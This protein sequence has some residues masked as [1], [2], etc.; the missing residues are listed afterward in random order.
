M[1]RKWTLIAPLGG[2]QPLPVTGHTATLVDGKMIVLF[3]Y[4]N[5]HGFHSKVQEFDLGMCLFVCWFVCTITY[6]FVSLFVCA[7]GPDNWHIGDCIFLWRSAHIPISESTYQSVNPIN[8]WMNESINQSSSHLSIHPSINQSI[9]RCIHPSIHISISQPTKQAVSQVSQ[10][11]ILLLSGTK[12]I[13]STC[14]KVPTPKPCALAKQIKENQFLLSTTEIVS[15]SLEKSN[16]KLVPRDFPVKIQSCHIQVLLVFFAVARKW[17]IFP[18]DYSLYRGTFGHSSVYH[19][20]Q[21]LIYLYGGFRLE[22]DNPSDT[23]LSSELTAYNPFTRTWWVVEECPSRLWTKLTLPFPRVT[24]FKFSLQ[25]H[26]KYYITHYEEVS[27]SWH[28]QMKNYYTANFHYITYTYLFLKCGSHSALVCMEE[29]V[30]GKRKV[31]LES[32]FFLSLMCNLA[33]FSLPNTTSSSSCWSMMAWFGVAFCFVNLPIVSWAC[34]TSVEVYVCYSRGNPRYFEV[35]L[36]P[37]P[38]TLLIWNPAVFM[39]RGTSK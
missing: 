1:T 24:N 34:G 2:A 39:S 35:K 14:Y 6:L 37:L 19:P 12:G 13:T 27:F 21:K 23:E 3:G 15:L 30:L 36:I 20:A 7:F 32:G 4:G 8:E 31:P 5:D 28:T 10:T 26:P 17:R 25:P 16:Y 18:V 9:D 38:L 33:L 29:V 11:S 22:A